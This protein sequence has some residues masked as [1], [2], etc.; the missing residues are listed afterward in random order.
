MKGHL[1]MAILL[2]RRRIAISPKVGHRLSRGSPP[3]SRARGPA[4]EEAKPSVP[5]DS[6]S[7]GARAKEAQNKG[8][9]VERGLWGTGKGGFPEEV[10]LEPYSKETGKGA[11]GA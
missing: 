9:V 10:N 6:I 5:V 7:A 2:P 1:T 3:E 11:G 4:Q 8:A